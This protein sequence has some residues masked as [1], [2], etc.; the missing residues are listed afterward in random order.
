MCVSLTSCF[1]VLKRQLIDL[2]IYCLSMTYAV[3]LVPL[4]QP[5]SG[6]QTNNQTNKYT[7]NPTIGI[8]LAYLNAI[9]PPNYKNL[10]RNIVQRRSASTWRYIEQFYII[11][12]IRSH[13]SHGIGCG[14]QCAKLHSCWVITKNKRIHENNRPAA[15]AHWMPLKCLVSSFS[16]AAGFSCVRSFVLR[17]FEKCVK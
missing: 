17:A 10:H 3:N 9:L 7:A 16:S 1:C 14:N 15:T 12:V 8:L 5:A 11:Y 4:N 2:K 6:R 13:H